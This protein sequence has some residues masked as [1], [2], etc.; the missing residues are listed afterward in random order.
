MSLWYVG[1]SETNHQVFIGQRHWLDSWGCAPECET[2]CPKERWLCLLCAKVPTSLSMSL[3]RR[4]M[5][6]S[7]KGI[8]FYNTWLTL[9]PR[10]KRKNNSNWYCQSPG[11]SWKQTTF[12]DHVKM[13]S[14]L[15]QFPSVGIMVPK[16]LWR[17]KY[18]NA[19]YP[20]QLSEWGD[21]PGPGCLLGLTLPRLPSSHSSACPAS[22]W[23]QVNLK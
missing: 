3:L 7:E 22:Y 13:S 4:K 12:L 18:E 10:V 17:Q 9:V 8:W 1:A 15:I 21:H 11:A 5:S 16:L 6:Y 2:L 20:N 19:S 23:C 14:W